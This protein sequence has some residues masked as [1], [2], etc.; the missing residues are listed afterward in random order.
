MVGGFC[1]KELLQGKHYARVKILVRR[2]LDLRHPKLEQHIVDFDRRET[3]ENLLAADDAFSCLGTTRAKTSSRELYRS[4][5]FDIPCKIARLAIERGAKRLSIVSSVGADPKSP[6]FYPRLK[7][8]I[9]QEVARL[10]F[11]AVHIFRPSLLLGRRDES[12]LTE[13]LMQRAAPLYAW[14]C[15]GPWRRYRPIRAEAVAQAMVRA[16]LSDEGGVQ[17]HEFS[18][19]MGAL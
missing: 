17:I 16:A 18:R 6:F 12:R 11:E 1:L 9:D 19:I 14:L 8:E 4:I 15:V 3:F 10:P 7:G 13:K 5:D 2:P